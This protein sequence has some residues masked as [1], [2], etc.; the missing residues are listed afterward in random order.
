VKTT[1]ALPFDLR[2]PAQARAF[3]RRA[4]S[5]WEL[6]DLVDNVELV[7]SE[8]VS[9]AVRHG[10]APVELTL[11]RCPQHLLIAVQDGAAGAPPRP[12]PAAPTDDG[13]RGMRLVSVLADR[14]GY[15]SGD[16]GKTVW[17]ELAVGG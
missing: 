12:R 10:A 2:A 3:A 14:W 13:G 1:S 7:V 9:N 17:A 16:A 6:A 8:L 4:L 11:S 15:D 5:D